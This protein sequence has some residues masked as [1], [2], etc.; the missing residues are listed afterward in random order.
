MIRIAP[1]SFFEYMLLFLALYYST[2]EQHGRMKNDSWQFTCSHAP[3]Q[4]IDWSLLLSPLLCPFSIH[5]PSYCIASHRILS[6]PH[7]GRHHIHHY[8]LLHDFMIHTRLFISKIAPF[9]FHFRSMCLV[10]FSFF[11]CCLRLFL[12]RDPQGDKMKDIARKKK[13]LL[14]VG[15][16]CMCAC[17][18][19][20][21]QIGSSFVALVQT[22]V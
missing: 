4:R 20:C 18:Y 5:I 21:M 9:C 13:D 22:I 7:H 3:A 1:F 15:H 8:H 17:L 11:S 2:I 16:V 12:S 14:F 6:H 10:F 19:V